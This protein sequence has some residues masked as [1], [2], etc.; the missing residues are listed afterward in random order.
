MTTV[1]LATICT[2]TSIGFFATYSRRQN[3]IKPRANFTPW[4]VLGS[5][6]FLTL[7]ENFAGNFTAM[8]GVAFFRLEAFF[9][10]SLPCLHKWNGKNDYN[11]S[12]KMQPHFWNY[13]KPE[14]LILTISLNS[15]V[16]AKN[17]VF[18]LIKN[19][20]CSLANANW[21]SSGLDALLWVSLRGLLF[22][23]VF[24]VLLSQH[25]H[26]FNL[27]AIC[28]A[29]LHEKRIFVFSLCQKWTRKNVT[30]FAETS[31]SRRSGLVQALASQ[32][33]NVPGR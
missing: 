28:W 33:F 16:M 29:P 11:Q 24:D 7:F 6:A 10:I 17:I 14:I 22:A 13:Q 15:F 19:E 2:F 1:A 9:A 8:A 23:T 5:A 27:L 21:Y 12:S 31:Y 26:I 3:T 25:V 4:A 18:H 30:T 32:K 20:Q